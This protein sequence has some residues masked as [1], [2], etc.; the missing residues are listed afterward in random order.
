MIKINLNTNLSRKEVITD[1]AVTVLQFLE[2]EQVGFTGAFIA[3]NGTPL[4]EEQLNTPIRELAGDKDV[5]FINV[6]IK[7][8]HN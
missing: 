3:F 6:I 1:D 4:N 7:T 8:D 2:G 5:C